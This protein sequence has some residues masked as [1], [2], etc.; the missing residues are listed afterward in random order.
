MFFVCVFN[1]KLSVLFWYLTHAY[2]SVRPLMLMCLTDPSPVS[3]LLM[4]C[5]SSLG[6]RQLSEE[7]VMCLTDPSPSAGY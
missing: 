2:F 1:A 3:W 6:Y 7:G 5:L 4:E